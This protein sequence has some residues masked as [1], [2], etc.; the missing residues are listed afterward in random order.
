MS[1]R[2]SR[3]LFTLVVQVRFLGLLY[4]QKISFVFEQLLT[5]AGTQGRTPLELVAE[6]LRSHLHFSSPGGVYGWGSGANYQLGTASTDHS[7]APVR[8]EALQQEL[9]VALSAA[10]FHSA[11]LTEGGVLYTW[12]WG[13]GGRLGHPD[14]E[15][16]STEKIVAQILPRAVQALEHVHVSGMAA[17]KH[18]MLACTAD[19]SVYATRLLSVVTCSI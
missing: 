13:R 7:V 10:K 2:L 1:V 6:E 4:P 18:H 16:G 11:A 19:G 8:L 15:G 3:E 17:A 12:G 9:V 14:F 5:D